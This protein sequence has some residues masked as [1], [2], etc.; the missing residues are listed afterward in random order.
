MARFRPAAA[1]SV[2]IVRPLCP[3]C[4][5]KMHLARIEP[6]K[7]GHEIRTFECPKCDHS[8]EVKAEL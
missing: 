2:A 7:P 6:D 8:T 3:V 5:T 4:G 1:P